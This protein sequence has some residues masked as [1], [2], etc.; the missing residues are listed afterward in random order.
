MLNLIGWLEDIRKESAPWKQDTVYDEYSDKYELNIS[1]D[2]KQFKLLDAISKRPING[3]IKKYLICCD[4]DYHE[5]ETI[6]LGDNGF[7]DVKYRERVAEILISEVMYCDSVDLEQDNDVV[8]AIVLHYLSEYA[9]NGDG[10]GGVGGFCTYIANKW[11]YK[12]STQLLNKL[13]KGEV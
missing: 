3:D 8:K 11:L 10:F 9:Y 7:T 4:K 6:Y 5:I 13:S 2:G 12:E 1:Y